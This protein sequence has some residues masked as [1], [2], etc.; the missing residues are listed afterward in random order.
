MVSV[1][2]WA[3][4][5][6]R[7]VSGAQG[8]LACA[9]QASSPRCYCKLAATASTHVLPVGHR[10]AQWR[11][12][13]RL[14]MIRRRVCVQRRILRPHL[15]RTELMGCCMLEY[16]RNICFNGDGV[17]TVIS[18]PRRYL[19]AVLITLARTREHPVG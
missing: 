5:S 2:R 7:A 8:V 4:Q 6:Y 14:V 12:P 17:S 10:L 3:R 16:I 18:A 11:L 9:L 19:A 1:R 13:A 15:Q